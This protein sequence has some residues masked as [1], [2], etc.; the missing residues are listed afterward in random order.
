MHGITPFCR[1]IGFDLAQWSNPW[2]NSQTNRLTLNEEKDD[3]KLN[4]ED[5]SGSPYDEF[6]GR[7]VNSANSEPK[8]GRRQSPKGELYARCTCQTGAMLH[9]MWWPGQESNL[10]PSR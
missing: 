6:V 4:V 5:Y 9:L 1:D 8:I 3:G 7:M 10:R 2:L